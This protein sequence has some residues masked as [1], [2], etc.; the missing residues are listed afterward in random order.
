MPRTSSSVPAVEVEL[1]DA[2]RR[3]AAAEAWSDLERSVPSAPLVARWP[4]TDTWLTH[5]GDAVHHRFAVLRRDGRPCGAALL[6]R[7]T[8]RRSRIRLRTLHI[9]TAGGPMRDDVVVERNGLLCAPEDLDLVSGALMRRLRAE[10]GFD[11]LR[12]DGMRSTDFTALSHAE[13]S[14]VGTVRQSPIVDLAAVRRDGGDVTAVLPGKAAYHVRRSLRVLGEVHTEW[15]ATAE[16]ADDIFDELVALH[17]ARWRSAGE[18]GA[19]A[20]T[21]RLGFARDLIPRLLPQC[22]IQLFRIRSADATV[23]CLYN[24]LDGGDV[25]FWQGGLLQTDDN[26]CKPGYVAHTQCMQA[27]LEHGADVYDYLCGEARY[28]RELST[29]EREL[30]WARGLRHGARS[31]LAEGLQR[32]RD[33]LRP[34]SE[35]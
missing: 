19:F 34:P 10:P 5:Y 14:L 17:Q 18:P 4:W 24:L 22:E 31:A 15:A 20:S 1:L 16:E 21:R 33:R 25:L 3:D 32:A 2:S 9:G 23:G 27:C 30:V 7:G 11:E 26:R 29:G 12:L 35:P 8:A 13:P 28:K 6:V